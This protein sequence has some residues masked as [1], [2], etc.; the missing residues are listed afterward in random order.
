MS[1]IIPSKNT[2]N[3]T[4]PNEGDLLGDLVQT[5]N[6]DFDNKGI[7]QLAKRTFS[8]IADTGGS[9]DEVKSIVYNAKD[10][11]RDGGSDPYDVITS[12]N[13]FNF[14]NDLLDWNVNNHVDNNASVPT[15]NSDSDGVMW[16]EDWY[17]T[18][19]TDI[20][21][22]TG[23]STWATITSTIGGT[24]LHPLCVY[25]SANLLLVGD[26]NE[27]GQV[28]A[29]G[30][31][32]VAVTLPLQHEIV[33]IRYHNDRIYIGTETTD[34]SEA[35]MFIWGGS[36]TVADAGFPVGGSSCA[37]IAVYKDQIYII[38]NFGE[39]QRF[40][41]G[42][43]T[44]AGR[45]PF[46]FKKKPWDTSLKNRS[47]VQVRD[48]LIVNL[49]SD[50][51]SSTNYKKGDLFYDI[52]TPSG[53]WC[54]NHDNGFY[55][56]YAPSIS[57]MKVKNITNASVT[58]GTDT[59]NTGTHNGATGD[60]VMVVDANDV[61]TGI[62]NYA[63]YY[64]I[65]VSGTELKFALTY[66][67]AIAGTAIDI[68]AGGAGTDRI[69]IKPIIDYGQ[70]LL[71]S[72]GDAIANLSDSE[73]VLPFNG[74]ELIWSDYLRNSSGTT[75][76]IYHCIGSVTTGE[77]RG[78]FTT[79][80]IESPNIKETWTGVTVKYNNVTDTQDKIIVKYRTEIKPNFPVIN[81]GIDPSENI[82]WA[83]TTSFTTTN[84]WAE[85]K[86]DFDLGKK[87]EIEILRYTGA[88][89]LA[90]ITDITE[91]A[92]TYTVTIDETVRGV[93]NGDIAHIAVNN[94][95]KLP[96]IDK[97]TA[98]ESNMKVVRLPAV[99]SKWIQLKLELRGE[100]VQI[101]ELVLNNKLYQG[102]V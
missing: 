90:H 70:S 23:A 8:F 67:D 16:Q 24:S 43:F 5:R 9:F 93:S 56:R 51:K 63:P 85:I 1:L 80:K 59:L 72:A 37:T 88:G 42:G 87:Y 78:S 3:W 29:A 18:D 47:A 95:Q 28:T 41:G 102:V 65:K 7:L 35:Y 33:S 15:G 13:L 92:G 46:S 34:G 14:P 60:Q 17:V 49:Y 81:Y 79:T 75:D 20:F 10:E 40:N 64:M 66:D 82:L 32:S 62:T 94:W 83:D 101:E 27:L 91:A 96:E 76:T 19:N 57:L 98:P 58:A 50:I 22:K 48:N 68:S 45:L 11:D 26:G 71:A 73:T 12:T 97:D 61:V 52:D 84:D 99:N 69:I 100:Q 53:L 77:N 30:T 21:K 55:H 2:K 74:S 4:Q 25:Q 6:I 38:N 86:A 31:Y 36:G 89:M 54:F 39:L 44:R